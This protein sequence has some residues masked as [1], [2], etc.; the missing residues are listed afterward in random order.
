MPARTRWLHCAEHVVPQC[1]HFSGCFAQ[2]GGA[3]VVGGLAEVMK[4]AFQVVPGVAQLGRREC[5]REV[6]SLKQTAIVKGLAG[7]PG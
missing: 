5:G 3:V 1:E 4:D 2:L 6:R 7:K